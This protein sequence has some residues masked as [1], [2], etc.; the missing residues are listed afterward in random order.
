MSAA[1]KLLPEDPTKAVKEV[2]KTVE[3]L[4]E[5]MEKESLA[6]MTQDGVSFTA[7]Q[8]DKQRLSDKY[9]VMSE[10]F[11]MRLMDFRAVD[12]MLLDKLDNLQRQRG[13]PSGAF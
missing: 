13:N 6:L 9:Q 1:G 2:I 7:A 10:E 11:K 5:N 12:K 8:N 3:E 4:L